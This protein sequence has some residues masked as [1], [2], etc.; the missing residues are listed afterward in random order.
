LESPAT[1]P[2]PSADAG[3]VVVWAVARKGAASGGAA[4]LGTEKN[5]RA[6]CSMERE[7]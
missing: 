6:I 5:G 7:A 4:A 1:P 3:G 2:A